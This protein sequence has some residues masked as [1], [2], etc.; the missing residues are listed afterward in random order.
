MRAVRR[1]KG[2]HGS[3]RRDEI[4]LEEEGGVVVTGERQSDGWRRKQE[5]TMRWCKVCS[6]G[7]CT[8]VTSPTAVL[9]SET[10]WH[11]HALPAGA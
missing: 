3:G 9:S 2:R 4:R 6:V 1:S 10:D 7:E 5:R 8:G 11:I